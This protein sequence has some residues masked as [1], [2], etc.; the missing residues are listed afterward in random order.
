[1]GVLH[2]GPARDKVKAT[3]KPQ[4][5]KMEYYVY[6]SHKFLKWRIMFNFLYK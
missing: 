5:F 3:Q 4:I 2:F 1:M 6:K